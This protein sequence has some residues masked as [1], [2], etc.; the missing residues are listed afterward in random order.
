M[1]FFI[2]RFFL[3]TGS[4]F[5]IANFMSNFACLDFMFFEE[6]TRTKIKWKPVNI[7]NQNNLGIKLALKPQ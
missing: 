2:V 4:K 1:L 7:T 3:E 5:L 6:F